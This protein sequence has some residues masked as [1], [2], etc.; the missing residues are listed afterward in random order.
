MMLFMS[1]HVGSIYYWRQVVERP[2]FTR[3]IINWLSA[4]GAKKDAAKMLWDKYVDSFQ[5]LWETGLQKAWQLGN[6]LLATNH[7]LSNQ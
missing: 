6:C 1:E 2:K 5:K 4:E 7:Y 3:L